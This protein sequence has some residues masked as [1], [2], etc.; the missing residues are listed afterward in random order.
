MKTYTYNFTKHHAHLGVESR[1]FPP[2]FPWDD[3]AIRENLPGLRTTG[4]ESE[5]SPWP[6]WSLAALLETLGDQGS[7]RKA[8]TVKSKSLEEQRRLTPNK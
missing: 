3:D 5:E 8:G 1:P 7:P 6:F 2:K 4:E